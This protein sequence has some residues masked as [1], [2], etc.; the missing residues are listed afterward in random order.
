VTTE[1]TP[2]NSFAA[3]TLRLLAVVEHFRT[4]V[5]PDLSMATAAVFLFVAQRSEAGS[6]RG[7]VVSEVAQTL[8]MDIPKTSRALRV[9]AEG[10]PRSAKTTE[11]AGYVKITPDP[12]DS[13]ARCASLTPEGRRFLH[14]LQLAIG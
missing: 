9:L 1:S 2:S 11:G 4:A 3:K 10:H 14:Q 13:R 7:P 8:G 6:A 5:D 12:F